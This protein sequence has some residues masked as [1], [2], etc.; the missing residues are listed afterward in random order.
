MKF[1]K[2]ESD[3]LV[4]VNISP[5]L[6]DWSRKVSAPQFKAKKF[7]Y[8]YWK[9]SIVLEEFRIPSS[10]YRIDLINLSS[11]ICIEISP[12]K[13]HLEFNKFMHGN[14]V[15]FHKKIKADADKML[16]AERGGFTFLEWYDEDLKNL[17]KQYLKE[18]FDLDL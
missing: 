13:L 8:P 3:K 7:L 12:D 9:S 14:R 2:F 16:W 10:L 11:K 6:I 15:G 5:Y 4:N 1:L 18:K 17:S